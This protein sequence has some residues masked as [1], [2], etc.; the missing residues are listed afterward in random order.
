[1]PFYIDETT[2]FYLETK[3]KKKIEPT[4]KIE[5][6]KPNLIDGFTIIQ[7]GSSMILL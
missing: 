1:M 2:L 5:P 7:Y 4:K 6:K 3:K